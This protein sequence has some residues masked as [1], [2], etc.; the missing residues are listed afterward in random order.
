MVFFQRGDK[1]FI[2]N[3]GLDLN[4]NHHLKIS[5]KG[6]PPEAANPPWDGGVTWTASE[7]GYPWIAVS[8]Q[9]NGAHI[10]YPCKEHPSDKPDSVDIYVT[11]P[12][13]LKVASNGL[14][15][16][17]VNEGNRR[18]TWHWKTHYPISTYNVKIGRASCRE[19]V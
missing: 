9:Q 11:V 10:W 3:P 15:Q 8:C 5:Y 19:R 13:P 4:S 16:G 12:E 2:E 7:D 14:L 1:L 6:K 17:I 18:E